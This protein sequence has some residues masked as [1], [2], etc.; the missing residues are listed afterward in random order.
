MGAAAATLFWL[1]PWQRAADPGG[2]PQAQARA[3]RAETPAPALPASAPAPA[4]PADARSKEDEQ[5]VERLLAA[6]VRA[7]F[8]GVQIDA[9]TIARIARGEIAAVAGDLE[10]RAQGGDDNANV[11]LSILQECSG[12]LSEVLQALQVDEWRRAARDLPAERR[13]RI[14]LALEARR[15]AAEAAAVSCRDARFDRA[16]IAERLRSASGNGH[17]AS[18]RRLGE[19][20]TDVQARV[21][22][23][24]SAAML[25]HLPAQLDLAQH[26]RRDFVSAQRNGGRMRFW[27][28]VA[29]KSSPAG[30]LL[31]ADCQ[32]NGCN[33][34]PDVQTGG[35]LL[36]EAAMAGELEALEKLAEDRDNP[37]LALEER[38]AWSEFRDRLNEQ[39]CFGAAEYPR[40]NVASWRVSEENRTA[41]PYVQEQARLFAQKYWGI[42][43]AGARRGM[44]CD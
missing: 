19:E 29:A 2:E 39:G 24:T 28:D 44:T 3:A 35:R 36:R 1:K 5:F 4:A 11:A 14:D 42:S 10:R 41:S 43:G 12:T 25:G 26:Y 17:E 23:W 7:E 16:A 37:D 15:T 27:M 18:L 38:I 22:L 31:L 9:A 20:T 40:V 32:L 34:P 13:A 21:K 8:A 33:A 30:K 6:D